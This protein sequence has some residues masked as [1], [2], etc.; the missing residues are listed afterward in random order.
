MLVQL[1]IKLGRSLIILEDGRVDVSCSPLVYID[2][3][4]VAGRYHAFSSGNM[5]AW[6]ILDRNVLILT[7]VSTL[8]DVLKIGVGVTGTVLLNSGLRR[9]LSK[10]SSVTIGRVLVWGY[11]RVHLGCGSLS[12]GAI[13]FFVG[14]PVDSVA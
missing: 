13:I 7:E 1:L 5:C 4:G 6:V 2:S 11:K 10:T 3:T 12:S 14:G 9:L 8:A